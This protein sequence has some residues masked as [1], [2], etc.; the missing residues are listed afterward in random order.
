VSVSFFIECLPQKL[1]IQSS[2]Q[3]FPKKNRSCFKDIGSAHDCASEGTAAFGVSSAAG[4]AVAKLAPLA[5]AFMPLAICK[6]SVN[7]SLTSTYSN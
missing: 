1:E 4:T 7:K 5:G 6:A 3:A 2:Q